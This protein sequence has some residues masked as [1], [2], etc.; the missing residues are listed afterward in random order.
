MKKIVILFSLIFCC[1]LGL[2]LNKSNICSFNR[3]VYIS[4]ILSKPKYYIF[5]APSKVFQS[6]ISGINNIIKIPSLFEEN[7]K[8]KTQLS[9][10]NNISIENVK[11]NARNKELEKICNFVR[12]HNTIVYSAKAIIQYQNNFLSQAI[13]PVSSKS[14][15]GHLV[16]KN[17]C[18]LGKII[19]VKK[20]FCEIALLTD[21]RCK[22]LATAGDYSFIVTGKGH[23]KDLVVKYLEKDQVDQLKVGQTIFCASDY[24]NQIPGI[25]IGHIS[26]ISN[27]KVY[28]KPSQTLNSNSIVHIIQTK[29]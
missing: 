4:N 19:S 8:L 11:L 27:S 20:Y 15:I 3:C 23:N 26:K 24:S 17:N 21:L 6:T 9:D 29:K 5:N 13:I 7:K 14:D 10:Y 22:I 25:V 16:L 28:I 12:N 1:I 2:L 18:V